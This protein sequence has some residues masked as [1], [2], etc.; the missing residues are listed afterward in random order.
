MVRTSRHKRRSSAN[1]TSKPRGDAL[2]KASK[3]PLKAISVR[4]FAG[5]FANGVRVS[6]QSFTWFFGAG[7]SISSGILSAGGLVD[8]W[9]REQHELQARPDEKFDTWVR[10]EFPAYNAK[11][12]AALYA[13]AFARRHPSPVER[14]REIEMICAR[15]EPGYGYATLAQILSHETYGRYC[16]TVLTTNFDDLVADALYLYGERHARP[17]VVTHEALARYVRTN[18]PRPTVVKLHGDAHLDPKNLQ[19]E[20]HEIDGTF[21]HQLYPFLQDQ[22]L[23]F[24]GYG[25]NDE[26]IFKFFDGSPV[27][28]LAPPIFWVS[29]SEPAGPFGSWLSRR[30]ALRVDHTDF[31]QLMHLIR[32]AL[33]IE[34]LD[35]KRW[36][37]IGDGYYGAFERLKGEIEKSSAGAEDKRALKSATSTAQETLPADWNEYSR[38]RPLERADPDQAEKL[39]EKAIKDFPESSLLLRSYANF[40]AARRGKNDLAEDY[41]KRALTVEPRNS[42]T[43]INY[44]VFLKNRRNDRREAESYYQR[45]IEADPNNAMALANYAIFLKDVKQDFSGAETYYKRSLELDPGNA[46]VLTSYANFLDRDRNNPSAAESYYRRAVESD[47][48]AAPVLSHYAIFLRDTRKDFDEAEIN[49]KRAL[50]SEPKN[51][52]V[53]ASYAKFLA[54]SRKNADRAETHYKRALEADPMDVMNLVGYA[55]FLGEVRK[56]PAA[57]EKHYKL[58]LEANPDSAYALH[59]YADFLERSGRKTAEAGDLRKRARL[60]RE[61]AARLQ[62]I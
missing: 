13:P 26:S 62:R 36:N 3:E 11:N 1:P 47:S 57:A 56:K 32:D 37:Q 44:A 12:P 33:K 35:R 30:N 55:N 34:L 9:L 27:P 7:C 25:A 4:E 38:I 18:S 10:A 17:L 42:G 39:Y 16:N 49:Y 58:A 43:L 46:L 54:Y 60:D 20:T 29:K 8:K 6:K 28:A 19:P 22:A 50:K 59:S 31:D 21:A 15:G 24:V 48:P 45:A 53:L 2:S 14:Q 52:F 41:F 5:R 23:I 51:A 40:L 61:T